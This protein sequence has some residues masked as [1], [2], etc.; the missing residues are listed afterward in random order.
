MALAKANFIL[1]TCLAPCT[2]LANIKPY[3]SHSFLCMLVQFWH[4]FFYKLY[5]SAQ[6]I[7]LTNV[8][9]CKLVLLNPYLPVS[10]IPAGRADIV[11][12]CTHAHT[13]THAYTKAYS[14]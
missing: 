8:Q 13:S 14:I 11:Y 1:D 7:S 9:F 6:L 4:M 5:P 10:S 2:I 12:P 3:L